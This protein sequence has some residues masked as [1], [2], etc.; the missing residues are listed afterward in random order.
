MAELFKTSL[1]EL[2]IGADGRNWYFDEDVRVSVS[3]G[4]AVSWAGEH[5]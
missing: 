2:I 5:L 1:G 4:A 3:A